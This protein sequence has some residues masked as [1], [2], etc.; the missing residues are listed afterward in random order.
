MPD[1]P[2]NTA[3]VAD[4]GDVNTTLQQLTQELRD[5]VVRT[6]TVP[7]NFDEFAAKSQVKFPPPPAGQ[8]YEIAGQ[9]VVLTKR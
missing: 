9:A 8:K 2:T 7:K 6:H 5:Y 1:S 4:T 3:V